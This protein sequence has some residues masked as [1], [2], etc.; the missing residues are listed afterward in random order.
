MKS[1]NYNNDLNLNKHVNIKVALLDSGVN[2]HQD[3]KDIVK[4]A[5]NFTKSDENDHLN[6]GTPIAGI[7]TQQIEHL[8]LIH[9]MEALHKET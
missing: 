8:K 4:E 1:I 6:H 7:G 2:D 3:L 9:S 5:K